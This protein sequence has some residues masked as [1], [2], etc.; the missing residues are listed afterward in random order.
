[1]KAVL[2]S[3]FNKWFDGR[4]LAAFTIGS[5]VAG[6]ILWFSGQIN[7]L[8]TDVALLKQQIDNI[9]NNDLAHIEVEVSKLSGKQDAE[10][11]QI[12]DINN[13]LTQVLT[14]LNQLEAK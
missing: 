7:P 14:I 2:E 13:K 11:I 1:M 4:I 10:Q 3:Q 12:N 6:C 5:I 8:G 9:K